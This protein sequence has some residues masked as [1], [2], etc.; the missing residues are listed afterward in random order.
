LLQWSPTQAGDTVVSS[1]LSVLSSARGH[2]SQADVFLCA[3]T[4]L[5]APDKLYHY[6]VS[7]VDGNATLLSTID[8]P[9]D[10]DKDGFKK[11]VCGNDVQIASLHNYRKLLVP[12]SS[13]VESDTQTLLVVDLAAGVISNRVSLPAQGRNNNVVGIVVN[14]ERAYVGTADGALHTYSLPAMQKVASITVP[15]PCTTGFTGAMRSLTIVPEKNAVYGLV[16]CPPFSI[17]P[18]PGK[19][20]VVAMDLF[21]GQFTLTQELPGYPST[22]SAG[23]PFTTRQGIT[24]FHVAVEMSC[25]NEPTQVCPA[26]YSLAVNGSGNE[27]AAVLELEGKM[28]RGTG[29]TSD[30]FFGDLSVWAES[31]TPTA[32]GLV[33]AGVDRPSSPIPPFGGSGDRPVPSPRLAHFSFESGKID[34]VTS[35]PR[36]IYRF[37]G[38]DTV[39]YLGKGKATM[40][41]ALGAGDHLYDADRLLTI[42]VESSTQKFTVLTSTEMPIVPIQ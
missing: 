2:V 5:K 22:G 14:E 20:S 15:N 23:L 17:Y 24:K 34:M 21:T 31:P 1:S 28:W 39:P 25:T 12:L 13:L 33:V 11:T 37:V 3:N 16:A 7:L 36:E 27:S 4:M 35:P 42:W 6:D 30:L 18:T 40:V 19:G 8:I 9:M 29:N 41:L 32:D 38:E 26:M 10:A